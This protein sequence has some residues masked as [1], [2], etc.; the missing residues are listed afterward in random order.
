MEFGTEGEDEPE[1]EADTPPKP[2]AGKK[3][4]HPNQ[5]P[6]DDG[7]DWLPEKEAYFEVQPNGRRVIEVPDITKYLE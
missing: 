7:D 1:D 5:S 2:T 4:G 3:K 6:V